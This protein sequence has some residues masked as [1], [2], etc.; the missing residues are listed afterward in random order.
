[1][2]IRILIATALA[3]LTFHVS[4]TECT[5]SL[6]VDSPVATVGA[7]SNMRYTEEHADG[8]IVDALA[9]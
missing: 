9:R 4:A 6:K 8:Y 5:Q 1:M 7:F 3:V 2:Q